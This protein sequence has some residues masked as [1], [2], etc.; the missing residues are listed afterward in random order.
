MPSYGSLSFWA[1]KPFTVTKYN[2]HR[3]KKE[4]ECVVLSLG[5][6]QSLAITCC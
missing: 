6:V 3:H 5:A 4:F 2:D 1:E